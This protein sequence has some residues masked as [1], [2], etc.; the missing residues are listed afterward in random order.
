MEENMK[1]LFNIR[2]IKVVLC[3]IPK[4]M[5]QKSSNFISVKLTLKYIYRKS[6]L[7]ILFENFKVEFNFNT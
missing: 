1:N 7:G 2:N 4:L 5:N 6:K 3:I